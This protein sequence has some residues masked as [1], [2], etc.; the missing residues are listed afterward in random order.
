MPR[1]TKKRKTGQKKVLRA[2]DHAPLGKD[3]R[4][5]ITKKKKKTSKGKAA[6]RDKV[7]KALGRR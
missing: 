1:I 2:F 4:R 7:N 6:T 3:G 5:S